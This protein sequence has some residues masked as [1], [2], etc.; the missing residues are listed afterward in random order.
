MTVT[1]DFGTAVGDEL[2][3]AL[4]PLAA[5]D[6]D[7]GYPLRTYCHALGAMFEEISWYATETDD[8]PGWARLADV[9]TTPSKALGWLAQFVGVTLDPALDDDAQRDRIR[10]TDGFKR[11]TVGALVGAAQQYLTGQKTVIVRER[12]G[13]AYTLTVVTYTAETP[14]SGLVAA[15]LLAQKPA[16][17]ILNY[18][19]ETGQDWATLVANSATWADVVAAYSTWEDVV[20]NT[21]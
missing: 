7:L 14:D 11:G 6:A 16:G 4:G 20:E 12:D 19:T 8:M 15:A 17:L 5:Q 10:M 2:Y 9:D 3:A 1:T 13:D 21:P 18:L